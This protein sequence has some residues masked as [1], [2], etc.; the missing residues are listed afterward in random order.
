MEIADLGLKVSPMNA[1][2]SISC[3]TVTAGEWES[4]A[5]SIAENHGR[6]ITLWG[7]EKRKGKYVISAVYE[8]ND[9]QLLRLDL[10][11]PKG[12]E[13][14]PDI[15]TFFPAAVRMQRGIMDLLGLE[16][17]GARDS[18]PWLSH[19]AWPRDYFPLRK[20]SSGLEVANRR[21]ID[22]YEFVPVAGDGVHEIAVGPV[23]AGIIEPGHFRFSVVGEKTLRLEERLG[24]AHKGVDKAFERFTAVEGYKLAGRMSGD[25][26]LAYSWSY[27]MS[28]ESIKKWLVPSR[29]SWLRAMA[30]ERERV[31]NHLGDLGAIGND[32]GFAFGLSQFMRLR[33]DWLRLN[34]EIF[35]H[36]LMMD[37]ICPGGV[38]RDVSTEGLAQIRAQCDAVEGEVRTLQGIYDDHSGLQDRFVT[39]GTVTNEL[40]TALGLTGLAGRASGIARDVRTSSPSAPY[41]DLSVNISTRVNGDVSARVEVRFDE[42]FESLRL[43]R[44]MVENLPNGKIKAEL[45]RRSSGGSGAGWI[46]GWRGGIFCALDLDTNG[47]INR[48]HI[49]DPSWQ[50]WPVIEYA[51]IGNIVPDFPLINK[52]FNLSYSGHDR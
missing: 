37:Y 50:N 43:I 27:C 2:F 11:L 32:A 19:G 15:S 41:P 31:G 5:L 33:E 44:Y 23:H 13:K 8:I 17:E 9:G 18:R 6:V 35:S 42:V 16:A 38:E 51:V 25:S 20:E 7:S 26:T 12:S 14:F 29:A 3:T 52:S 39:T 40:A 24:Y 21:Q 10:P 46:E 4:S 28:L 49:H 22:D 36:R 1:S 34:K 30:L 45:F 47:K 48:C